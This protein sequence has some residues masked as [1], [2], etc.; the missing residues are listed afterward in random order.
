MKL[1]LENRKQA[2]VTKVAGS[3]LSF[4]GLGVWLFHLYVFE[5]YDRTRPVTPDVSS[6]RIYEQNNH[7]HKVYLTR[8]ED[9]RL[10]WL[11][12]LFVG[13]FGSGF[14]VIGVFTDEFQKRR[15]PQ[16]FLGSR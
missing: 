14:L 13:L 10:W 1:P 12:M 3:I 8:Q 5:V 11:S 16:N 15:K 2:R 9:L 6:G 4:L 7:G